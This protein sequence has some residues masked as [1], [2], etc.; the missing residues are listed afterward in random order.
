MEDWI[1]FAS[2]GLLVILQLFSCIFAK[3]FLLRWLPFF[4]SLAL[5]SFCST[6]YFLGGMLY[7]AFIIL[8]ALLG[9]VLMMQATIL[10]VNRMIRF[11]IKK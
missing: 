9:I 4:V 11:V 2:A 3:R 1:I 8:I 10:V 6:M 5:V 7:W